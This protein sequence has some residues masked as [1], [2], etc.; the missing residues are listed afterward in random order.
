M[1]E[2]LSIIII[3]IVGD[4]LLWYFRFKTS[5]YT[6]E[7]GNTYFKTVILRNLG[8]I[9]E[10]DTYR[11]L[12]KI[13]GSKKIVA[14][15]YLPVNE[16]ETTEIDLVFI[17]ET[18]IYVIESKNYSGSIYGNEKY[19]NWIQIL[20]KNTKNYF[21]NP[22]WQNKKHIKYLQEFIGDE[23]ELYSLIIFSNRCN[24]RKVE[25]DKNNTIVLKRNDLLYQL[26]NIISRK[27]CI[28]NKEQIISIYQKLKRLSNQPIEIKEK[29][30]RQL[31]ESH[32]NK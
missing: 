24:L 23:T 26:K 6:K 30:I 13:K 29:H 20:N 27:E 4:Y 28:Y 8:L 18:G 17:H 10:F 5:T 14:N 25:Y 31:K 32:N 22:I 12:E 9:G 11:L 3:I 7:T 19:K 15:L 2:L 1:L 16:Q 21:F